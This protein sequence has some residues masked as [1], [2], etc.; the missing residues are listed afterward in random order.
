MA[1]AKIKVKVDRRALERVAREGMLRAL[2]GDGLDARCPFC[3]EPITMRLPETQCP[4]C[5]KTFSPRVG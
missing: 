1:K 2:E 3:G 5:G 4:H